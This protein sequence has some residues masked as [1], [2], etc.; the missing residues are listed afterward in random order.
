MNPMIYN[1]F[2]E[3]NE[4]IHR[5]RQSR[6]SERLSTENRPHRVTRT[7]LKEEEDKAFIEKVRQRILNPM[8][9]VEVRIELN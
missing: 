9:G 2:T 5:T 7:K 8:D 4:D 1:H 3:N 6:H